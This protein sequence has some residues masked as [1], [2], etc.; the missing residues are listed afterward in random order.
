M[1]NECRIGAGPLDKKNGIRKS[2]KVTKRMRRLR[3]AKK[4]F[5]VIIIVLFIGQVL[6]TTVADVPPPP[7][8]SGYGVHTGLKEL[9]EERHDEYTKERIRRNTEG[10]LEQIQVVSKPRPSVSINEEV[11]I[12]DTPNVEHARIYSIVENTTLPS[13]ITLIQFLINQP[14]SY[15]IYTRYEDTEKWSQGLLRPSLFNSDGSI[16]DWEKWVEINVDDNFGTGDAMGY[17]IR[18]KLDLQINSLTPEVQLFPLKLKAKVDGGLRFDMERLYGAP[19]TTTKLPLEVFV[20]KSFSYTGNNYIW[21]VGF[22]F[23]RGETSTA[24]DVFAGLLNANEIVLSRPILEPDIWNFSL[25]NTSSVVNISGPYKIFFNMSSPSASVPDIRI[26]FAQAKIS[27]LRLVERTWSNVDVLRASGRERIPKWFGLDLDSP[28]FNTSFDDLIWTSETSAH[29]HAVFTEE[30]ENSTLAV[31]DV[32]NAGQMFHI[33]VD[34][35]FS[36]GG[37]K[38]TSV[39]YLSSKVI[40]RIEYTEFEYYGRDPRN[41]TMSHVV[42]LDM[43]TELYLNGTFEIGD[44]D[45]TGTTNF[46]PGIAARMIDNIMLKISSKLYRIAKTLR[47]IPHHILNLPNNQG[48]VDLNIMNGEHLGTIEFQVS[49]HSVAIAPG[50]YFAFRNDTL[51]VN[52]SDHPV[53]TTSFCGRLTKI[54]S[55]SVNFLNGTKIDI[56]ITEPQPFRILFIDDQLFARAKLEILELPERFSLAF[57]PNRIGFNSNDKIDIFSYT[58]LVKE[59]YFKLTLEELPIQMSIDQTGE[60]F[61][62]D[63]IEGTELGGFSIMITDRMNISEVEAGYNHIYLD[64]D[65]TGHFASVKLKDITSLKY[66]YGANGT[67]EATFSDQRDLYVDLSDTTNQVSTRMLFQPFPLK[68]EVNLPKGLQSTGLRMPNV[69]DISS[70]F[71]FSPIMLEMDELAT[72]IVNMLSELTE[73]IA[74]QIG[75][76]GTNTTITLESSEPCILIA[77]VHKG[78]VEPEVEWT[79]GVAVRIDPSTDDVTGKIYLQL[80]RTARLT[81]MT[82][83]DKMEFSLDFTGFEP[84]E[85]FLDLQIYGMEGR[86]LSV[87]MTDL[88]R[89]PFDIDIDVDLFTN[90]TPGTGSIDGKLKVGS[91]EE[92]GPMWVNMWKYGGTDSITSLYTSSL[93]TALDLD[94]DVSNSLDVKWEASEKVDAVLALIQKKVDGDWYDL[95]AIVHDVPTRFDISAGAYDEIDIDGSMLQALPIITIDANTATMDVYIYEEGPVA[96]SP[97]TYEVHMRDVTDGT[98]TEFNGEKY[99][100]RSEG[101]GFVYLRVLNIPYSEQIRITEAEMFVEGIRS[102]TIKSNMAFGAYPIFEITEF[103]AGSLQLRTKQKLKLFGS[104]REGH[105]V[106]VDISTRGGI[107]WASQWTQ[108]GFVITEGEYH[109]M[110]PA[111]FTSVFLS[112]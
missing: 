80:P 45:D 15:Y 79:H 88:P 51:Y 91:T 3:R 78:Q 96:G 36:P 37:E 84:L 26:S 41:F 60:Q 76:I 69:L 89:G 44:G 68:F 99:K 34:E 47:S 22:N 16:I 82:N 46:A 98:F 93:P 87:Y 35:V 85:K 30:R 2:R 110:V 90:M 104:L 49:S 73:N 107:P 29:I 31:I 12:V 4:I 48:W 106:Y 105:I 52:E 50:N 81:S 101:T 55:L 59:Q 21:M 65:H 83:W 25:F 67:L 23:S 57:H 58:S 9:Q 62:L 27:F 56:R 103:D 7:L 53:I 111:P 100:I 97:S 95:E 77:E 13:Q 42:F 1:N 63:L 74:D 86:D 6:P 54:L 14:L 61:L 75:G 70:I 66:T 32:N 20:V 71:E 40:E 39:H 92:I 17:D 8:P 33:E 109:M 102:V 64:K 11:Q 5:A 72:D 19:N 28:S 10:V 43:P 18:C 38:S 94:I 108:D 24:P 112:L